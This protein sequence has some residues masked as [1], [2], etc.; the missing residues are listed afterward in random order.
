ME[1]LKY[2]E[3]WTLIVTAEGKSYKFVWAGY[4]LEGFDQK[5]HLIWV[6]DGL[7]ERV[8]N[9]PNGIHTKE[10]AVAYRISQLRKEY[11][12]EIDQVDFLLNI[13]EIMKNVVED[14]A[15]RSF[16]G[17]YV[18]Q[19]SSQNLYLQTVV[20][21]LD[22]TMEI[23]NNLVKELIA[24]KRLGIAGNV[25]IPY[26]RYEEERKEGQERSGHKSFI[27]SDWGFWACE[28][29]GANG[30]EESLEPEAIPCT[31]EGHYL[32]SSSGNSR[33]NH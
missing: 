16:A 20:K 17:E 15:Q 4:E 10:A 21:I 32:Y 24:E 7:G 9:T 30:D 5:E 8:N 3:D 11:F 1:D 18:G 14:V 29:C 19:T 12:S 27:S 28:Y 26:E 25:L 33:N 2:S 13:H 23:G 6:V 22:T 31:A